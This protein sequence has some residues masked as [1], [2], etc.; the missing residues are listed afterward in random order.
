M[1]Y[2]D[3]GFSKPGGHGFSLGAILLQPKS[4]GRITLRS[5]NPTDAPSIDPAYLSDPADLPPLL[6][7]LKLLRTLADSK[8]F[9]AFRGKPVFEPDDA[10]L[11]LRARAETIYHPVGTCK[12]GSDEASVVNARLEVHGVGR[13]RVVDASVMPS[14]VSG[15]T[16]AATMM[17]AEKAAS[18]ISD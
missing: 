5:A 16:Q 1:H 3:H 7:G 4:R 15:N 9:D 18:L 8:A 17:I 11:Y 13:L 12:M 2:V 6:E 14:I 10:E